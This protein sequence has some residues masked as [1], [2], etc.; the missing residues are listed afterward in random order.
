VVQGPRGRAA[1]CDARPEDVRTET[2]DAI[3]TEHQKLKAS[4]AML[5]NQH[6]DLMKEHSEMLAAGNVNHRNGARR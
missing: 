3:W 1:G 5:K 4:F 2:H 6:E